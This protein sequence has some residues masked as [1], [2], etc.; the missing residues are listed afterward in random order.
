M[1]RSRSV[2]LITFW[3]L[4]QG[5]QEAYA[6]PHKLNL[7]TKVVANQNPVVNQLQAARQLLI[8][9]NQNYAG[10]RDKASY[11]IS[12]A[13]H[14][15]I[16]PGATVTQMALAKKPGQGNSPLANFQVKPG[17]GKKVESRAVADSQLLQASQ[18]LNNAQALVPANQVGVKLHIQAALDEIALALR[19]R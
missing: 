16:Y 17:S 5:R 10:H 13:L 14:E 8:L 4:C 12:A 18:L 7:Y 2:L 3:V 11:E 6:D 15:M 9:A 19:T 1:N